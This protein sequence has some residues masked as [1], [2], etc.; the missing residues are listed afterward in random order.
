MFS[1]LKGTIS[2]KNID[3]SSFV[4]EV[5][6][7]GYLVNA[8][9]KL[10]S[11]IGIKDEC[12]IYLSLQVKEDS[13]K[14]YGFKDRASR[15]LFEILLSVSGVGPKAA[16]SILN[17]FDLDELIAAVLQDKSKLIAEAQGI[18][19]KTAKRIILELQNK[20]SK[21]SKT[22]IQDQDLNNQYACT[23]EVFAMLSNLGYSAI[24]IDKSINAAQEQGIADD[25]ELLIQFCLKDLAKL[26]FN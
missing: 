4:I 11:Q 9:L 16:M 12:K 5:N 14:L 1:Y 20:L 2:E 24:E 18:G 26:A 8:N 22:K 17:L 10:L 21:F 25:S 19:P 15:D 3:N 13:H 23:E 7:I 6:N